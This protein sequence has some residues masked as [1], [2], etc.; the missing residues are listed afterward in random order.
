[1]DDTTFQTPKARFPRGMRILLVASLALNL[2]VLGGVGGMILKGPPPRHDLVR[3]L[4]FGAFTEA[5]SDAD[6]A[7]L[8]SDFLRRTPDLQ[9][10]RAEM[11]GDLDLVLAALRA[12]PFDPAA[13]DAAMARQSVRIE[14]RIAMG[15][16]LMRDRFVAMSPQDRAAFA[17]RLERSLL[18]HRDDR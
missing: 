6:R 17:D 18:R 10:K 5:L 4:G 8:R 9:A 3:D 2:L 14:A 13:L 15:Q 11:R 7:A 1:M 12:T 16:A